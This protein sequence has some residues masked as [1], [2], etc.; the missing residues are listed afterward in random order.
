MTEMRRFF[1]RPKPATN[2]T[3]QRTQ[4]VT[5]DIVTDKKRF[6]G[7]IRE[8]RIQAMLPTRILA[9]RLGIRQASLNQYFYR[10]RGSGGTS[11]LKWFLRFAEA[12]GC[13]VY[14]TFPSAREADRLEEAPMKTA[15]FIGLGSLEEQVPDA[16]TQ[17][18]RS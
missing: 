9:N 18:S 17:S 11:T 14:I 8:M 6:S 12:C 13:R 7:L 5:F 1:G 2:P 10:K 15:A 4:G 3:E 16:E